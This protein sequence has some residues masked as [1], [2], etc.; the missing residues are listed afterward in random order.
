MPVVDR[1][2]THQLL[3]GYCFRLMSQVQETDHRRSLTHFRSLV[4]FDGFLNFGQ[5]FRFQWID[6]SHSK[7]VS[8]LII[9][10]ERLL[11]KPG[12]YK[13]DF[14][15]RNSSKAFHMA[16]I[17]SPFASFPKITALSY[18]RASINAPS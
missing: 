15:S 8:C 4:L 18:K 1:G 12:G 3:L 5:F 10:F 9:Y 13:M 14:P 7:S 16:R 17:S 2:H 11:S 6:G